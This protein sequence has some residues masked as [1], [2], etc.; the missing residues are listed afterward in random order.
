MLF[1]KSAE[2]ALSGH[3]KEKLKNVWQTQTFREEEDEVRAVGKDFAS[4][5]L[6]CLQAVG[7]PE[8]G[9]GGMVQISGDWL[10]H[11]LIPLEMRGEVNLGVWKKRVTKVEQGPGCEG[12]RKE[13]NQRLLVSNQLRTERYNGGA[14]RIKLFLG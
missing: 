7:D 3:G 14:E 5:T 12:R 4:C 9:T 13:K 2:E 10:V 8:E 6:V 1:V 11:A